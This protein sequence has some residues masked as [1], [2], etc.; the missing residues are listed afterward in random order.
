MPAVEKSRHVIALATIEG[1]LMYFIVFP[2]KMSIICPAFVFM[3]WRV[4]FIV[5][6]GV[7]HWTKSI[8][9]SVGKVMFL[10]N[11]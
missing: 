4:S 11:H 6:E 3:S 1:I 9:P 8:P 5:M 10:Y 2:I 7:F